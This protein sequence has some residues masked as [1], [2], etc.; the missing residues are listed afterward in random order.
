MM[1][2]P[3]TPVQKWQQ[4]SAPAAAVWSLPEL[5]EPSQRLKYD[6]KKDLV[7]WVSLG[8]FQ[9]PSNEWYSNLKDLPAF[10]RVIFNA[11]ALEE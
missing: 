3:T 11:E 9:E 8:T 10:H 5:P 6:S 7:H 4:N 2:A 1:Q